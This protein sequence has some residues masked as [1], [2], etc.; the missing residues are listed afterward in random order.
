MSSEQGI[1]STEKSESLLH[2]TP[3]REPLFG[4]QNKT[5]PEFTTEETIE[6]TGTR[7]AFSRDKTALW[8]ESREWMFELLN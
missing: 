7:I 1:V 5:R 4:E 6:E 3:A 8:N 2:W